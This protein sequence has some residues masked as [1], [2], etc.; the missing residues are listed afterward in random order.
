MCEVEWLR[1]LLVLRRSTVAVVA[2]YIWWY[3]TM[4]FELAL[5]SM[6]CLLPYHGVHHAS[7][8]GRHT[9]KDSFQYYH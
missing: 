9:S 2:S 5:A 8:H 1:L 4:G 6:V 3:T 7:W